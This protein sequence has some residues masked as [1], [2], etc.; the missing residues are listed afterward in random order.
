MA[1]KPILAR[2]ILSEISNG[3][4]TPVW[5]ACAGLKEF[6]PDRSENEEMVDTT[7]ADSDGQAESLA[8]Q[9]GAK[10]EVK[11]QVEFESVTGARDPG[12]ARYVTLAGATGTGSEGKFR[13]R[14]PAETAWTVWTV[15]VSVK[16][17]GGGLND[18]SE[19][20]VGLTKSGPATTMAVV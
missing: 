2:Q 13:W 3:A 20:N 15:I 4:G 11:G 17:E 14:Y 16:S 12:Q 6:K 7:D 18:I 1:T 10:F 8:A 9:R 19:F 5:L